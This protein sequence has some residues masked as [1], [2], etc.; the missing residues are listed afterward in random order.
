MSI[1]L[2]RFCLMDEVTIP[3]AVEL[4]VAIGEG[5]LDMTHFGEGMTE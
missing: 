2:E 1:A 5:W 4:S 3:S